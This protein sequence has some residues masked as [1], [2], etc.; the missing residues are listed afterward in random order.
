MQK[1]NYHKSNRLTLISRLDYILFWFTVVD[2]FFLPYFSFMSVSFSVPF[3]AFW[4]LVH[5]KELFKGEERF[6][7]FILILFMVAGT[8]MN[9]IY[10]DVVRRET[11]F[12]TAIKRFFQFSICFGYYFFYKYYFKIKKV[13]INRLLFIFCIIETIWAIFFLI[14]PEEYALFKIILNPVDNHTMRYIEGDIPLRFNYLWT[15]PNNIAYLADGIVMWFILDKNESLKNKLGVMLLSTIIVLATA[16]NGGMII[17]GFELVGGIMMSLLDGNKRI[18]VNLS[19]VFKALIFIITLCMFIG[20]TSIYDYIQTDL[21]DKWLI[22][23]DSYSSSSNM[24][25]GRFND[26]NVAM[27]YLSPM[28]FFIGTGNEGISNENGPLYWIGMYG[29]PACLCFIYLWFAKIKNINWT[30]YAWVFPFLF[31]FIF[32]I[33]IGEF[34]FFAIYLFMLSYSRY[35]FYD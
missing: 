24:S 27:D 3:I 10:T 6:F 34:K 9:L 8:L 31:A 15:D 5:Y 19:V 11:T 33:A 20:Y 30:R 4:M 12:E 35:G 2:I 23:L 29:F 7:F 17:L 1:K 28:M 14:S 25:G 13:N 32:N 26:I 22:R 18:K 21:I 16:S